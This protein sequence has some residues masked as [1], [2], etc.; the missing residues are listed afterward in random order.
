MTV[1]HKFK[2]VTTFA[3]NFTP[4]GVRTQRSAHKPSLKKHTS[5]YSNS[6][7]DFHT[8]AEKPPASRIWVRAWQYSHNS[9]GSGA[10]SGSWFGS[11]SVVRLSYRCGGMGSYKRGRIWSRRV[12]N[13]PQKSMR[14]GTAL[15]SSSPVE[16][17]DGISDR[18]RD[19]RGRQPARNGNP[20]W[21][22]PALRAADQ[23]R[24]SGTARLR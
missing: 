10:N 5:S 7:N 14:S 6:V 23:R 4:S 15:F 3:I 16:A 11:V 24:T 21:Q 17:T 20:T 2:C 8:S 9:S 22:S 18:K 19:Q 1:T 12:T 13:R